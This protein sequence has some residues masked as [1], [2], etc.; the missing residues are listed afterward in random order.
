MHFIVCYSSP[1]KCF[2]V[3]DY[4]I[5]S[6]LPSNGVGNFIGVKMSAHHSKK[7]FSF[8]LGPNEIITHWLPRDVLLS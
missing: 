7:T 4:M 1:R 6:D 2:T 3:Y 5:V 8:L